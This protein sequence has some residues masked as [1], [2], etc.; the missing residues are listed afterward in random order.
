MLLRSLL[1]NPARMLLSYF[2][3]DRSGVTNRTAPAT[4][5]NPTDATTFYCITDYFGPTGKRIAWGDHQKRT[6]PV[7]TKPPSVGTVIYRCDFWWRTPNK[8]QAK[9]K[10]QPKREIN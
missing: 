9:G 2:K 10:S 3:Q 4:S 8:F 1:G 7:N 6:T 5:D